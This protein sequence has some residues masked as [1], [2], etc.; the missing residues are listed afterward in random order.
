MRLP[1][2]ERLDRAELGQVLGRRGVERLRHDHHADQRPQGHGQ[3]ERQPQP[4]AL[5]PVAARR[6]RPLVPRVDVVVGQPAADL[7]PDGR[8]VGSRLEPDD[9]ERRPPGKLVRRE[10]LRQPIVE[11]RDRAGRERERLSGPADDLEP[12]ALKLAVVADL[13]RTEPPLGRGVEHHVPAAAEVGR[14]ARLDVPG[15]TPGREVL[16]PVVDTDSFAPVGS[17]TIAYQTIRL[18]ARATPGID[19]TRCT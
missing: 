3:E 11:E 14:V 13:E 16:E 6:A 5:D 7:A 4:G 19:R 12:A 1:P 15:E 2:P 8:R 9:D 18:S 17:A 10:R